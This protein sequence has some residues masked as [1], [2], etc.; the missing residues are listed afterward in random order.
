ME[1]KGFELGVSDLG[2]GYLTL[3]DNANT[4]NDVAWLSTSPI[5]QE[6]A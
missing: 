4:Y 3:R 1:F 5:S 6:R 2:N